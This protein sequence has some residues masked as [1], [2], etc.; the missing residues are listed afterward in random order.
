M[1]V[2]GIV[3]SKPSAV[4]ILQDGQPIAAIAEERLD[5]RKLVRGVPH[6]AIRTALDIAGVK[7]SDINQIGIAQFAKVYMPEPVPWDGW[8]QDSDSGRKKMISSVGSRLAPQVGRLPFAPAIYHTLKRTLSRDRLTKLPQQLRNEF[9]LI[10]PAQ[11]FDH[12]YCHATTAYY[13]SGFA[14][15]LVVTMDGGGDGLSATVST[16]RDGKLERIHT[17]DSFHSL[18]NFYSY[19]TALCGFKAEKH[20]GKITG[21]AAL[22]TPAYAPHLRKLIRYDGR[23]GCQYLTPMYHRSALAQ[24]R[25]VLPENFEIGDLAASVQLVLEEIGTDIVRYWLDKTELRHLAVAG[26]VFA[27][28]KF[29]QRIHQLPQVDHFF[30]YPAMSDDG[31]AV[32]S[33]LAAALNHDAVNVKPAVH[34]SLGTS[35]S[36]EQVESAI[37]SSGITATYHENITEKIAQILADGHVVARFTGQMEYGPRALGNRSIMYQTNDPSVNQWLNQRLSRTE[38]MPFAPATLT[39]Y[40]DDCYIGLDG[41]RHP[42]HFMTITFDCTPQMKV[43]SAGCVHVDGTA[44]PQLVSPKS[45]P[46]FHAILHA[47]HAITGIPSLIN[48]SFNLHGEP[49]VCSPQDAIRSFQQGQLD[50]LALENWLISGADD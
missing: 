2:M 16:A 6:K 39:E 21:L 40:A 36:A 18:G 44:R 4:A 17:I 45:A 47:Y 33:A 23:G 15:C 41:A 14:D 50:Y 25:S 10:A 26:G 48:T 1:I 46:D 31:L 20:E 34:V 7:P 22:G 35:Y 28:V 5:R 30:V 13:S 8:F 38:F 3:D 24:I 12:H 29:N 19:I 37:A 32:G 43:Q 42:A 11:F 9:G 49:I 27:N